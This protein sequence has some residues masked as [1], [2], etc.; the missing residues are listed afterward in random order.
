MTR[1]LGIDP[2]VTTGIALVAFPDDWDPS[3]S[4]AKG[5]NSLIVVDT[6]EI[7]ST[8]LHRGEPWAVKRIVTRITT[9]WAHHVVFEDFILRSDA[10]QQDRTLLAP[11]RITS[12]VLGFLTGHSLALPGISGLVPDLDSGEYPPEWDIEPSGALRWVYTRAPESD[13]VR[14]H[15][16]YLDSNP[17]HYASLSFQQPSMAK[18]TVT[19][20]RLRRWGGWVKGQKHSRDAIRHAITFYLNK[21]NSL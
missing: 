18:T 5:S 20:E 14:L 21:H 1:V 6:A 11:V 17:R 9:S 19:D 16:S 4:E 2:G 8:D 7:A 13:P 15:R 12:M 3:M 10:R